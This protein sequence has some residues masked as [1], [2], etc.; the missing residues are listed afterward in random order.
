M[1]K[2]KVCYGYSLQIA[3]P[4]HRAL[5]LVGI[6]PAASTSS[7]PEGWDDLDM[8]I[9]KVAE[10]RFDS[11]NY[12]DAVEAALKEVNHRIKL[13]VKQAIGRELDGS[14]LMNAAFS[15][16][17]PIIVLDDLSTETGRNIQVGYMQ[18]FAGAMTGIR[19]P[20]ARQNIHITERRAMQF[21]ALSSLLMEK[22]DEAGCP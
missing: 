2:K 19:N 22:L 8:R 1:L 13:H 4:G 17:N 12:A 18:I 6:E 3:P 10:T 16:Q 20:K 21:L 14:T 9:R 7:K 11:R 15:L 5:T